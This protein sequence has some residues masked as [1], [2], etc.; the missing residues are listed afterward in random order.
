MDGAVV[1][2]VEKSEIGTI[3]RMNELHGLGSPCPHS[4]LG[5]GPICNDYLTSG[6]PGTSDSFDRA[7]ER[8]DIAGVYH[9]CC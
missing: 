6:L 5:S 7:G 9:F 8:V 4:E 3:L 1:G 2:D